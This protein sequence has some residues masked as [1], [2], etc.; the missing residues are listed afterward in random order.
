MITDVQ[1]DIFDVKCDAI[2]HQANCFHT[3]GS[4]IAA[5]IREKF[6]E[7]YIADCETKRGDPEK[8]GTFSFAKVQN[9][10]YP[11]VKVIVNLYSQFDFNGNYRCT[12]Y[13]ALTDGLTALRD[14]M[15][16]KANGKLRTLAIPFRIGSNRGGGDWRVVRAIIESVFG[17]E[18]DFN[19]LICDNPA[20]R[21]QLQ[22]TQSK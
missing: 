17:D 4:G 12:R 5:F 6:P 15:R 19:V 20:L 18:K 16:S 21:E 11:N 3:M 22:N 10:E 2:I 9:P 13:D 14:K 7:A 8:I 1:S